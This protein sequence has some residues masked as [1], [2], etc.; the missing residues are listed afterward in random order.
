MKI[1]LLLA[2]LAFVCLAGCATSGSAP[3]GVSPALPVTDPSGMETGRPSGIFPDPETAPA[4]SPA[5]VVLLSRGGGHARNERLCA[6]FIRAPQA[7]EAA[8]GDAADSGTMPVG[9]LLLDG[10]PDVRTLDDCGFILAMYDYE[11]S[12]ELM[13]R[14]GV[15]GGRG[16][17]LATIFA[18]GDSLDRESFLIADAS[19]LDDAQIPGFVEEWKSAMALASRNLPAASAPGPGVESPA[20]PPHSP[21]AETDQSRLCGLARDAVRVTG[22]VFIELGRQVFTSYPGVNLIYGFAGRTAVGGAAAGAFRIGRDG[23][24]EALGGGARTVCLQLRGWI[25]ERV[26]RRGETVDD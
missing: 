25:N 7:R 14:F 8:A 16:P 11:R 23:A 26:M 17:F 21:R 18:Q 12:E 9:M 5:A 13:R 24:V 19:A 6:E 22:P 20:G 1:R 2:F 3:P 10:Q 4:S 15:A